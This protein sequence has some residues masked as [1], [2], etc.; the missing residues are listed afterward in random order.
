MVCRW[1]LLGGCLVLLELLFDS[2]SLL[3]VVEIMFDHNIGGDGFDIFGCVSLWCF[4][5]VF[6]VVLNLALLWRD[7]WWWWFLVVMRVVAG[8]AFR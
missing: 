4:M 7:S 2:F 6:M 1:M 5:T 8:V 3:V